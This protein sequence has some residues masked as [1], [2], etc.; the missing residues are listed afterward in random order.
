[1]RA[2]TFLLRCHSLSHAHW[3][4]ALS[5]RLFRR[6]AARDTQAGA[7]FNARIR[8]EIPQSVELVVRRALARNAA[9][10]FQTMGEL[11]GT[12]KPGIHHTIRC[13]A[14]ARFIA[15]VL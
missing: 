14:G 9:D 1:M 13:I 11:L 2:P 8:P 15:T 6:C 12:V 3:R 7:S 4:H 10:R 5:R